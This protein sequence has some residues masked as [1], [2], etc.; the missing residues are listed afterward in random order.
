MPAGAACDNG[1][2]VDLGLERVYGGTSTPGG[3]YR[4]PANVTFWLWAG[5]VNA[6]LAGQTFDAAAPALALAWTGTGQPL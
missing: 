4:T 3:N 6:T 5:T 1:L 2:I